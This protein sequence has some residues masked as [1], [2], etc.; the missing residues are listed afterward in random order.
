[1][2]IRVQFRVLLPL[3]R[4]SSY[5]EIAPCLAAVRCLRCYSCQWLTIEALVWTDC[6]LSSAGVFNHASLVA[7]ANEGVV[8]AGKS[9][10]AA[11]L[12]C[13]FGVLLFL[14]GSDSY[15]L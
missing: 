11:P 10:R 13:S 14:R 4:G 5:G 7:S 2:P 12:G 15:L 8:V 6:R 1:M 3:V 9:P